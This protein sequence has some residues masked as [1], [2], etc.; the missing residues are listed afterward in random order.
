VRGPGRT[1]TLRGLD[2]QGRIVACIVAA[3]LA[4]PY[5]AAA[6]RARSAGWLPSGDAG[7]IGLFARDVLHGPLPLVG[8]PTTADVYSNGPVVNHPGPIEFYV[9]ALPM[10]VLGPTAGMLVWTVFANLG[11]ALVAAWVVFRRCGPAIGLWAAV[12]I[13][14]VAWSQGPAALVDPINSDA[15]A[16]AL[17]A[18]AVLAWAV[19]CGDRRL[20]PLL[21]VWSAYY[22]QLHLGNLPIGLALTGWALAAVLVRWALDRSRRGRGPEP[23]ADPTVRWWPWLLGALGVSVVLWGPVIVDAL[24][25][26]PSNLRATWEYSRVGDRDALGWSSALRQAG[27]A[28]DPRPLV[29]RNGVGIGDFVRPLSAL[30]VALALAVVGALAAIA[31]SWRR[32]SPAIALLALTSLVLAAVGTVAA[33]QVPRAGIIRLG[34]YRWTFLLSAIVTIVVGAVVIELVRGAR[35]RGGGPSAHAVAVLRSVGVACVAV[36]ALGATFVAAPVHGREDVAWGMERRVSDA[37]LPAVDGRANVHLV[38]YGTLAARSLAM[39]LA[40]DLERHGHHVTVPDYEVR[41]YGAHRSPQRRP[42]DV[43]LVLTSSLGPRAPGPG[44]LLVRASADPRSREALDALVEQARSAPVAIAPAGDEMAASVG[45]DP[46]ELRLW[47]QGLAK[48]PSRRLTNRAVLRLFADGYLTSP[49]LDPVAMDT[50][51]DR[52]APTLWKQDTVQVTMLTPARFEAE[53]GPIR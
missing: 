31:I 7:M 33:A 15:G 42:P 14:G 41:N 51:L 10:L 24:T 44:R 6:V 30:D 53:Y 1:W 35:E 25:G 43:V 11:S 12:V 49:R 29:L 52:G 37:V 4:L 13:A 28:L 34:F 36:L 48:D 39:P 2:R 19:A 21:A 45:L 20:L 5:V 22:S 16:V 26:E 46:A 38:P 8:T 47:V 17:L 23:T 18:L 3:G 27:R 32:R 50:L 9:L 40:L